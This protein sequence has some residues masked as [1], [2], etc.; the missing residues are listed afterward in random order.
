MLSQ[1]E[2]REALDVASLAASEA[3]DVLRKYWKQLSSVSSKTYP[4]D[5]VSEADKEA[6]EVAIACLHRHFPTY[7][8]LAEESGLREGKDHDFQWVIDP[9]DGTCNYVHSFPIYACSIALCY[10]RKPILGVIEDPQHDRIFYA[11]KGLGARCNGS[12]I[13]VSKAKNLSDALLLTGF[14]RNH[15]EQMEYSCVESS[16]ML[17]VGHGIRHIGSAVMSLAYIANGMADVFW[18]R[19]LQPWDFAAGAVIIEEAGGRVSDLDGKDI[20]LDSLSVFATN[21][22]FHESVLETIRHCCC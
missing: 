7:A 1:S 18:H 14:A 5:L 16:K 8:I 21:G 2:L 10:K 4:G 11:A 17:Q 13:Q 3:A 12:L 15:P 19:G 20:T 9:L 6:E 22:C